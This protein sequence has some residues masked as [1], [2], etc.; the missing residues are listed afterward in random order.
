MHFFIVIAKE[1]LDQHREVRSQL[2]G[3]TEHMEFTNGEYYFVPE[4]EHT[5]TFIWVLETNQVPFRFVK[6]ASGR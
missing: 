1:Q 3:L 6:P 4:Q 2:T 5:N